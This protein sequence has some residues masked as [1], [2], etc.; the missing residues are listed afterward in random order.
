[1]I[2]AQLP[3]PAVT[4]VFGPFGFPQDG[5]ADLTGRSDNVLNQVAAEFA[6]RHRVEGVAREFLA[7]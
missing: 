6:L 2:F 3:E 5:P 1:L 4:P 7:Q